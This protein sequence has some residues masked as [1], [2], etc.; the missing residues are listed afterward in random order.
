MDINDES[1]K[2]LSFK[3]EDMEIDSTNGEIE[4]RSKKMDD[5]IAANVKRIEEEEKLKQ[6]KLKKKK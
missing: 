3:L 5:K 1:I 6:K 2:D 4:E